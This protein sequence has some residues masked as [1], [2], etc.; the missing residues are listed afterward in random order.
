MLSELK[1]KENV[2]Q[3][4]RI[5]LIGAGAMGLGIAWKIRRTTGVELAFIAELIS[6][7]QKKQ[8]IM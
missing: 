8:K 2:G 1:R 3:P 6:K 5:G 4:I 7:Q